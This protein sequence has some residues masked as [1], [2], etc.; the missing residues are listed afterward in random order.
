MHS[1]P[2][3]ESWLWNFFLM[4]PC[5]LAARTVQKAK[6]LIEPIQHWWEQYCKKDLSSRH[7][8]SA[9]DA[10]WAAV[11]VAIQA[12]FLPRLQLIVLTTAPRGPDLVRNGPSSV[13]K[14][15]HSRKLFPQAARNGA[16]ALTELQIRNCELSHL[17]QGLFSL[18]DRSYEYFTSRIIYKLQSFN[19]DYLVLTYQQLDVFCYS[20]DDR[21][22]VLSYRVT[23]RLW[24]SSLCKLCCKIPSYLCNYKLGL[25]E[26]CKERGYRFY[27][28]VEFYLICPK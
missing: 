16:R 18:W 24:W 1:R 13:R 19:L 12:V 14:R 28:L 27:L 17:T 5:L 7:C 9:Y 23:I 15:F 10:Q 6:K 25:L 21:I 4:L 20:S 8:N 26:T 11:F 22:T 3:F 2:G